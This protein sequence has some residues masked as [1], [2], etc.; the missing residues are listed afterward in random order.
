MGKGAFDHDR[1]QTRKKKRG[2]GGPTGHSRHNHKFWA[3]EVKNK[4]KNS[5]VGRKIPI[6]KTRRSSQG[7]KTGGKVER[8]TWLG[9]GEAVPPESRNLTIEV[10]R[11]AKSRTGTH[12]RGKLKGERSKYKDGKPG[13]EKFEYRA[14]DSNRHSLP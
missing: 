11:R 3:K 14:P 1:I 4:M 10:S 2:R 13:K 7:S 8:G 9:K 6:N 5:A 12:S